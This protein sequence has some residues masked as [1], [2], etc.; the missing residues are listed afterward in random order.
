MGLK[1]QSL[2]KHILIL[3]DLVITGIAFSLCSVLD[4][5][6]ENSSAWDWKSFLLHLAF[7]ALS[8]IIIR[9]L[10][11]GYNKVWRYAVASDY[12]EF[13]FVDLVTFALVYVLDFLN[14]RY[15]FINGM[16]ER[17]I[18]F[19]FAVYAVSTVG[20]LLSRFVYIVYRGYNRPKDMTKARAAIIGAGEA[21]VLL[22]DELMRPSSLYDPVVFVDNDKEKIGKK[23]RGIKVCSESEDPKAIVSNYGIDTAIIAIPS[24]SLAKRKEIVKAYT[25][26]GCNIRIFDYQMDHAEN[27]GNA[28]AVRNVN[29]E[30]L[31]G[32]EQVRLDLGKCRESLGE[33]TVLVTGAGGSIG[34]ELCSQ[35]AAS[36][37]K[38]L[39]MLDVYENGIYDVQ[40]EL[41]RKYGDSLDMEVLI[42]T[43]C[44]EKAISDIFNKYRPQIVFHAAAHKHVPLMEDCCREAVINNV[45]GTY[46]V[47]NVCEKYGV[48]KMLL[49]STDK[50]VN[51]TNVMG[52]TKRLCE[53]IILS[54]ADSNTDY[55]AVRFGNVLGS[56]GS[57]IPLFRR[58]IEEGGPVTV[59]DKRIVRYFMTIPEAVSLVL[60][61]ETMAE[62]SEIFVLDMGEPVKILDLAENMVTLSGLTPYK[63]ID[64][65]EVGLRPGEKLYEELLIKTDGLLKT[66]NNKIFI[67]RNT[68]IS[69]KELDD[70]LRLLHSAVNEN[71]NGKIKEIL[72]QVV[73]TYSPTDNEES[74]RKAKG[75]SCKA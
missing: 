43:V 42:A 33:K 57:V 32:R 71:D 64:I 28:L 11:Y 37:P 15:N 24:L 26:A 47:A 25:E 14:G 7:L 18:Y 72:A 41:K 19:W 13:V 74:R 21:G 62:N 55:V 65:V 23:V 30:D 54:K 35:I 67:D 70:K 49:I 20:I 52:A 45:F 36:G 61:T 66:E 34:S 22:T 3:I 5:F 8:A 17:S 50:A 53:M 46:N 58:Q 40:Q 2:R 51:P 73:P 68:I 44:D 69:R 4:I 1:N 39:I 16:N 56:N 6:T 38:K 60:E 27:N 10:I 29:I 9:V 31:L 59:T 63:D 48:E 75:L 12:I